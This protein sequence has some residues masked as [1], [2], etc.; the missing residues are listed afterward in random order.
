MY[1]ENNNHI[2]ICL[3]E[4]NILQILVINFNLTVLVVAYRFKLCSNFGFDSI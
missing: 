4:V 2:N 1:N 3:L